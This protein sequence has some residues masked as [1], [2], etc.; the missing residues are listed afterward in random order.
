MHSIRDVNF[1]IWKWTQCE[2]YVGCIKNDF[3]RSLNYLS[4]GNQALAFGKGGN[5]KLIIFYIIKNLIFHLDCTEISNIENI[6]FL[7]QYVEIYCLPKACIHDSDSTKNKKRETTTTIQRLTG[8]KKPF[9]CSCTLDFRIFIITYISNIYFY[10]CISVMVY[11]CFVV[12]I[13]TI[14]KQFRSQFQFEYA[15]KW[16]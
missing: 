9:S 13:G 2:Y 4:F 10:T 3:Q 12:S 8:A 16:T 5:L 6:T 11:L 14:T 7:I 1:S 15:I